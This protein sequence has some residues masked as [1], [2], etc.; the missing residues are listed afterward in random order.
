[1]E[2]GNKFEEDEF[3]ERIFSILSKKIKEK[4]MVL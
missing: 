2:D 1:L 3:V 4:D